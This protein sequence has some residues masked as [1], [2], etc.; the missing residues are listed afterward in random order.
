MAKTSSKKDDCKVVELNSLSMIPTKDDKKIIVKITPD[1][2]NFFIEFQKQYNLKFDKMISKEKIIH[3]LM[4]K[5][6]FGFFDEI[7]Y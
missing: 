7:E 2:D 5:A 3:R 6:S 4:L 1:V